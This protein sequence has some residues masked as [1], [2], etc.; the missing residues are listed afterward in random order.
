MLMAVQHDEITVRENP[1][2]LDTLSWV[3]ARHAL[4]ILD[5]CVLA[6][7]HTWVVLDVGGSD[8]PANGLRRV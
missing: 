7:G 1:P 4:E 6:I 8:L 5:E 3:L 2:K